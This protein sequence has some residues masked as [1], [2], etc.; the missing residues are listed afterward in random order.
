MDEETKSRL[1]Q[2][3]AEIRLK[4]GKQVTQQ[5]ILERLVN[6]AAE[7]KDEVIDSFR[8]SRV[9]VDDNAHKAFHEGTVASGPETTKDD[10]SS[11]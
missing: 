11:W 4:T 1:E 10:I 7:S 9:P 5:E 8:D 3:Q 6:D 2:L